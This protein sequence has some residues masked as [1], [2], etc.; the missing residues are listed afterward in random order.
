METPPPSTISGKN[1]GPGS[2]VLSAS[3]DGAGLQFLNE[4]KV[5]QYLARKPPFQAVHLSPPDL[6]RQ[7]AGYSCADAVALNG[8]A[9]GQMDDEQRRALRKG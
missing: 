1:S 8:R 3:G 9:W 2:L 5:D 7:W 4:A 6:P